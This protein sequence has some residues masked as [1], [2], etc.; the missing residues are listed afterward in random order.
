M[1]VLAIAEKDFRDAIRSR[2]LLGLT[3]LFLSLVS[4]VAYRV[5]PPAGETISSNAFL[6]AQ[7]IGF[8][9][10]TLVPLTALVISYNA[11]SGERESGS[12]KLLLSLPNSR[13]DVVFGKLIGRSMAFSSAVIIAFVIPAILLAVGPLEF[14][15]LKFV[16]Y[17]FFVCLLGSAFVGIAVGFSAAMS[18]QTRALIGALAIYVLFIPV[19]SVAEIPL[20]LWLTA[21]NPWWLPIEGRELYTLLRVGRPSGAFGIVTDVLLQPAEVT[22]NQRRI[23]VSAA[24]M[25]VFWTIAPPLVGLWKFD[26]DDL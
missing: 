16:T 17:V 6:N 2:W 24:A 4:F 23:Q 26:S 25:M 14:D 20:S 12:I 1:S 10:G 13:T 22:E 11:I 18:T 7:L 3:L 5:R 21:T 8:M 19:W 9:V 15:L